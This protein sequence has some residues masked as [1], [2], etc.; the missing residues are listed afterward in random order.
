MKILRRAAYALL[1]AGLIGTLWFLYAKTQ[2]A[3]FARENLIIADLRELEALDA[4]WTADSLRAKTAINRAYAE[5]N[6]PA[7]RL[8]RTSER[9]A[10]AIDSAGMRD[11]ASAFAG[12]KAAFA[13]KTA[14]TQRFANQNRILKASLLFVTDGSADLLAQLRVQQR[15]AALLKGAAAA[16]LSEKLSELEVRVNELLTETLK[17][18]LLSD[19]AALTRINSNLADLEQQLPQYPG[20]LIEPLEK[21]MAQFYGVQRQKSVEDALLN[22]MA[23][24]PIQQRIAETEK[25]LMANRQQV[26][27]DTDFY[28]SLL[29]GYS[30]FLLAL[31]AWFAW[32]L[33]ASYRL[34][35]NKNTELAHANDHL[36][37]C[38]S[39]RTMELGD[40]LKHLKESESALIQSEKMSSLGQMIAGVAHEINT[41]LA[42][43]RNGLQVLDEQLPA[44][45]SLAVQTRSLLDLLAAGD[46]DEAQVSAQYAKVAALCSA[47]EQGYSTQELA[48]VV[49]DGIHGIEQISEIVTN[50]KNFSRLDRSKVA[51]F[52]LNEGLESTL[53]IARNLIKSKI[54]KRNFS[55][56]AC[57]TGSPS[58][59]N[60]VFL[61]LI[62]NAA[63]ATGP[64]GVITLSTRIKGG[65]AIVQVADNGSG[66]APE[67]LPKIFDPFF[68]TK[69][70]GEGTGL[71]LSIAYKII[72]A[73]GG[74]IEATSEVGRGTC[75][76]ITLP[77][78]VTDDAIADASGELAHA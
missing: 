10:Q 56:Q 38:V 36:E 11:A 30:A 70:V 66:I 77:V 46:A 52:D 18:N 47:A 72:S 31:I 24:L 1:A 9:V 48:G 61:N 43:V 21:L 60:Q 62:S 32:R 50:L 29:I 34:I 49:K 19:P 58:Q 13:Q 17:Y 8:G 45:A 20:Y 55:P 74:R 40:A 57:I 69:K 4:E 53:V 41:P 23:A 76:T 68:T 28:R 25:Q 63:Q 2:S 6:T 15:D 3:D 44:N 59:I 16:S 35:Q 75:F 26:L 12:V 67:V 42:Y 22:E 39:A 33:V 14:L 78:E 27:A 37:E 64:D 73:H 65:N 71:G 54:I 51:L 5:G 7:D